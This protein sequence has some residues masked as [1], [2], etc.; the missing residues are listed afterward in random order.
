M[1]NTKALSLTIQKLWPVYK[2]F[3]D[4]QRDKQTNKQTDKQINTQAK[5][6]WLK[7]IHAT[8]WSEREHKKPV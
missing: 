4:K 5:T 8:G 6:I 3:E 1:P 2:S 7:F